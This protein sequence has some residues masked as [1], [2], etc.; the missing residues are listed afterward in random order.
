MGIGS[1]GGG[2]FMDIFSARLAMGTG[3]VQGQITFMSRPLPHERLPVYQKAVALYEP[4]RQLV[5]GIRP[6]HAH[7]ADQALRSISSI[8]LN[9]AG[10][11]DGIQ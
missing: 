3:E 7:L 4:V 8:P 2:G 6:P 9:I 1:G 5:A 11:S 10:G